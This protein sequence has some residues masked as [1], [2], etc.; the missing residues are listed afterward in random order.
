ME[1]K[2]FMLCQKCLAVAD[3][4]DAGHGEEYFCEC[5]GQWC[6]C[7]SCHEQADNLIHNVAE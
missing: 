6:G 4:D 7:D 2:K 5:G 3:Y 1:V